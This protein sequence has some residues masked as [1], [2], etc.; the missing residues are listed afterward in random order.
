M[1]PRSS[2]ARL[3]RLT[4]KE[5][6]EILRDRRTILTLVAM[7]LLLY[8]LLSVAFLQFAWL[9][10]AEAEGGTSYVCGF[11][12]EAEAILFFARLQD[13]ERSLRPT[14]SSEAAADLLALDI[15]IGDRTDLLDALRAGKL[16][17][18]VRIPGA[19]KLITG[20]KKGTALALKGRDWRFNC[21]LTYVTGSPGG[22][23]AL[24]IVERYLA[25]ADAA[26]LA[27]RL[28]LPDTPDHIV[29][30]RPQRTALKAEGEGG[31]MASLA[32]LV[33]L[34]LIL[35]TIT[36]AVYPAIDLTA[37]ERERGTLE[38]LVAAPVPRFALL[39][40]K[41]LAVLTV[42]VL[43][44][45]VNLV[46][47]TITLQ[48]S[49]LARQLL[50]AGGLS[51]PLILQLFALLLLFAAFFSAVLLCLTSFARSFKEAQAYLIPLMLGSLGPGVLAM[52]PGLTLRP[53]LAV[54]PLVNI[55][56]LARDLFGGVGADPLL[57]SLVVTTTLL[58]ALAALALAARVF[59]AE[60]VLYSEQSAWSDLLR[61]PAVPTTAPTVG[62]ALWCLALAVPIQFLVQGL[63]LPKP[64]ENTPIG[65]DLIVMQLVLAAGLSV[66]LFVGLPMVAAYLGRVRW[67]AGFGLAAPRPAAVVA[68]LVLGASLW[69]L[70]L[71]FLEQGMSL[72]GRHETV[73]RAMRQVLDLAGPLM[74]V[75]AVIAALTEECFFRGYLFAAL[76]ARSGAAVTIG[77]SAVLFGVTHVFLG[78]ALGLDRLLPSTVLGLVLGL[79]CWLS[80]S[81]VPGMVLHVCHNTLLVLLAQSDWISRDDVPLAWVAAGAVGTAVGGALLWLAGRRRELAGAG[82]RS[83][84]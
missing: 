30:L 34:I 22:L 12:R 44:A 49:G 37:G 14:P 40:A 10:K 38:I 84:A 83:A 43:T 3:G 55:V 53:E 45:V 13:G 77:V 1:A 19:G 5:L 82:V 47:M 29:T 69:P 31:G 8:P 15:H 64:E 56:L 73:L 76:R 72:E 51:V 35:M 50:P 59:G 20:G 65:A 39:T 81:I 68:G 52:M 61:R 62:S 63:L 4:R 36:G 57:A 16:D 9:G 80:G 41:Y 18:I 75:T 74:L 42:A 11:E 79:V 26:D 54:L 21:E 70:V 7:P 2:C 48:V 60:S 78:G 27:R 25:A 23:G 33:P 6:S 66:L 28:N 46:S 58:Y 17:L 71:R 32:A 24:A 67:R